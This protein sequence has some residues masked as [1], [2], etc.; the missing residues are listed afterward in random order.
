MAVILVVDIVWLGFGAAIGRARPT[1][2]LERAINVAMGAT[3]LA[4][5]ALE[6]AR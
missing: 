6:V 5:A 3:I 2:R 4:T 1:P